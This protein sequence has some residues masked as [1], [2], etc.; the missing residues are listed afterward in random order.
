[1]CEGCNNPLGKTTCNIL[2]EEGLLIYCS[3]ACYTQYTS[4]DKREEHTQLRLVKVD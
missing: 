2:T 4:E 3:L 1:M